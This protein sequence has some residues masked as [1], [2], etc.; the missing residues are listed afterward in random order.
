M[1]PDS[2]AQRHATTARPAVRTSAAF[3][4]FIAYS[5]S[6]KSAPVPARLSLP[7]ASLPSATTAAPVDCVATARSSSRTFTLRP[8]TWS[9]AAFAV[10]SRRALYK[11]GTGSKRKAI[12]VSG[13]P[14]DGLEAAEEKLQK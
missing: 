2:A 6:A 10:A 11:E 1:H 3:S 12:A 7:N 8:S 14:T 9:H 13:T 5:S 4:S